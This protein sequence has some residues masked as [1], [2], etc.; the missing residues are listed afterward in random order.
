MTLEYDRT[1][2]ILDLGLV[3]PDQFRG[4][5]GSERST[6]VVTQQWATPGY[7]PG[8]IAGPWQVVLGLYRVAPD[9]VDV[10]VHVETPA[11][12]PVAPDP[13]PLPP[14][15]D[16]PPTPRPARRPRPRVAGRRLPQPHGAF[17][18]FPGG[19]RTGDAGGQSRPRPSRRHRPQH[20]QPPRPSRRRGRPRRDPPRSWPGG[21]HRRRSRQLLRRRSAGSTSA[22]RPTCGRPRRPSV[23][24]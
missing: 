22:I 10:S 16:R 4:W 13:P 2:T 6:V 3:G 15:P 21:D 20:G 14:R 17:R 18:W 19:R 7:L 11:R 24:A 8:P 12:P 23:A 5:S 1:E 9:G